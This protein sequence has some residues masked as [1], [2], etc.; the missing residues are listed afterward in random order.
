MKLPDKDVVKNHRL[1]DDTDLIVK[2]VDDS[3]TQEVY[4]PYEK[5]DKYV[6]SI[7]RIIRSSYEYSTYIGILKNKMDLTRCR[8]IP[9]VDI[10]ETKGL[11]LEIHHYPFTLYELVDYK[12]N[13]LEELGRL[14]DTFNPFLVAR[15]V[16]QMHYQG[17]VGLVPLS[18]TVHE[19]VH[20]GDIFVPLTDKFVFGNWEEGAK[21][22]L[23]YPDD[24]ESRLQLLKKLT[25]DYVI[26]D[27]LDL[28]AL[29]HI[30]TRIKM[31][32]EDEPA[33]IVKE[34]E[35]QTA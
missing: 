29:K 12:I 9:D 30:Q 27:N 6:K 20:D 28:D 3:K 14:T 33:T 35:Q 19:L 32:H 7:E 10:T 31:D 34:E 25:K 16:M 21:L 17:R 4:E 2:T 18:V 11:S 15:A 8:F 26:N 23:V 24:T 22:D 5:R 1:V 13:Q